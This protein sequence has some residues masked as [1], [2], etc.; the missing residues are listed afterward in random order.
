MVVLQPGFDGLLS[1]LARAG[2]ASVP[3]R[4][5]LWRRVLDLIQDYVF[6][7]SGLGGTTMV[8]SSYSLLVHVPYFSHAHSLYLQIALEQGVPGLLAFLWLAGL[9][10]VAVWRRRPRCP[11]RAVARLSLTS[12]VALLVH[13]TLDSE[14][15]VSSLVPVVFLPI[16]FALA[17]LLPAEVAER[18]PGCPRAWLRRVPVLPALAVLAVSAAVC[19]PATRALLHANLGAVTQTRVELSTYH[20]PEWQIQDAVRRAREAS[21][22]AA[23]GHYHAALALNRADVT[24]NRRLGQI[25]LSLGQ[26]QLARPHLEAAYEAAPERRPTRQLLGEAY[27]VTGEPERAAALWRTLDLGQGQL[28]QRQ[29]WYETLGEKQRVAW[30]ARATE[31]SAH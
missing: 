2:G 14:L 13:G 11:D 20:W 23:I 10:L 3:S 17:A 24:A 16:G 18:P 22:A 27:A 4:V 28:G 8:Y 9:G 1:L 12:L 31:L 30:I 26:Y 15:Y 21:L 29:G 19:L 7:G 25:E 6:T 5:E